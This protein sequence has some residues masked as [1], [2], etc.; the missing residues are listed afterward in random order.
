VKPIYLCGPTAIG[1]SA[2]A[3]ELAHRLNGEIIS[4]DSMQVYRGMDIGT[5]KPSP[6]ERAAVPHHLIDVANLTENFDAA[7]FVALA[8]KAEAEIL[9]RKHVPIYCGGTGLYFNALLQGLGEAPPSDP[10]LRAQL[11]ATP[12]PR[13][14]AELEK[15]DPTTW[16]KIDRNNPRRLIRALEVIRLTNKSFSEQRADW[17]PPPDLTLFGLEIDRAHLLQ[18]INQRVDAMFAVGLVAETESLL[19]RGLRQNRTASQALGYRQVIDHLDGK[20]SLPATIELVK[21]RTRQ[22][23]KRQMTWFKRQLPVDWIALSNQASVDQ[24]FKELLARVTANP[25]QT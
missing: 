24:S 4:V 7:R 5:A 8:K 6:A 12:L 13:L 11:E 9:A 1:K 16:Q 3:L 21:L 23:A 10:N 20:L 2:L 18:R 15:L 22:F 14:L 19:T 25:R 17:T